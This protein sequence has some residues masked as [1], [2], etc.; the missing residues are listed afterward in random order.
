MRRICSGSD[1][2]VVV[3]IAVAISLSPFRYPSSM[4]M[5]VALLLLVSASAAACGDGVSSSSITPTAQPC[6]FESFP[7]VFQ[8]VGEPTPRPRLLPCP[9]PDLRPPDTL[10]TE[11][12]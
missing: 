4:R 5:L 7:E 12:P 6:V 11:V 9:T 1:I 8:E 3:E 2:V 10:Q